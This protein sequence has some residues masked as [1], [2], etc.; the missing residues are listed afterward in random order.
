MHKIL[1]MSYLSSNIKYLRELKGLNQ[2]QLGDILGKKKAVVSSYELGGS[3]PPLTALLKLSDYFGIDLDSLTKLDL[4]NKDNQNKTDI[5]NQEILDKSNKSE[6]DEYHK[7]YHNQYH[8]EEKEHGKVEEEQEH[9]NN[10]TI[11]QSS[12]KPSK[13]EYFEFL[14]KEIAFKN[15]IIETLLQATMI[16]EENIEKKLRTALKENAQKPL[17]LILQDIEKEV[18]KDIKTEEEAH[19]VGDIFAKILNRLLKDGLA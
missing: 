7:S 11:Q 3:E 6:N 9:Y 13:S 15:K 16:K 14:K 10:P 1:I 12:I 19:L 2:T 18:M 17:R 4:S 8:N 5:E